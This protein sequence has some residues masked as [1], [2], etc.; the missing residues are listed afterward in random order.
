MNNY[1]TQSSRASKNSSGRWLTFP[2]STQPA[3]LEKL[4]YIKE[5][6]GL[7]PRDA[8]DVFYPYRK[9]IGNKFRG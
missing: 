4:D 6:T 7:A 2:T 1:N 8:W 3:V 5:R 9:V